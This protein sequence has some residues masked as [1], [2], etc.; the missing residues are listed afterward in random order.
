MERL[1]G[2]GGFEG[3]QTAAL[4]ALKNRWLGHV[5]ARVVALEGF[6]ALWKGLREG[7]EGLEGFEGLRAGKRQP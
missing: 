7:L 2:F 5:A 1:E 3:G 6:G 4:N